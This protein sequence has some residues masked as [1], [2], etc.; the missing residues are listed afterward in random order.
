MRLAGFDDPPLYIESD[1]I[2]N[3]NESFTVNSSSNL[4]VN[5]N[6]EP[7]GNDNNVSTNSLTTMD[8]IR[9]DDDTNVSFNLNLLS[10]S[11]GDENDQIYEDFQESLGQHLD[12]HSV[13]SDATVVKQ[14]TDDYSRIMSENT[15]S[16]SETEANNVNFHSCVSTP[17][18][19]AV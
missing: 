1:D 3:S 15:V 4:D 16:T 8:E 9:T 6:N 2:N 12:Y 14:C 18:P 19:V 10:S 17:K 13:N 7:N 5:S 11:S